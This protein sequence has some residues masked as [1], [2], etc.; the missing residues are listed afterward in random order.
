VVT[1]SDMWVKGTAR[2][3]RKSRHIEKYIKRVDA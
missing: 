3:E 2:L 1:T